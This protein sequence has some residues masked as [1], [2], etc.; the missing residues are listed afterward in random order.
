MPENQDHAAPHPADGFND[1][2]RTEV[3]VTSKLLTAEEMAL[4]VQQLEAEVET[5][6]ADFKRSEEERNRQREI[7]EEKRKAVDAAWTALQKARAYRPADH[8]GV[9]VRMAVPIWRGIN[10]GAFFM[11]E[12]LRHVWLIKNPLGTGSAWAAGDGYFLALS[13]A[14]DAVATEDRAISAETAERVG[15]LRTSGEVTVWPDKVERA[16]GGQPMTFGPVVDQP[17]PDFQK[18]MDG[19]GGKAGVHVNVDARV[20]LRALQAIIPD[21][22]Q[23]ESVSVSIS[24]HSGE[25]VLLETSAALVVMTQQRIETRLTSDLRDE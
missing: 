10:H 19:I 18:V 22:H 21:S 13:K 20:L 25:R 12:G 15:L 16:V 4:T 14:G 2:P 24:A 17:M 23:N 5:A 1:R 11:T 9:P 7:S 3:R 8:V 6:K